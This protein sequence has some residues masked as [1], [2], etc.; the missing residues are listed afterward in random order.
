MAPLRLFAQQ[1]TLTLYRCPANAQ[2]PL[3]WKLPKFSN[4]WWNEQLIRCI[5]K[6]LVIVPSYCWSDFRLENGQSQR[7]PCDK[8]SQL[9]PWQRPSF[10]LDTATSAVVPA[11]GSSLIS[12]VRPRRNLFVV[13]PLPRN[14]LRCH[15]WQQHSQMASISLPNGAQ[16]SVDYLNIKEVRVQTNIRLTG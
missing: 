8:N 3:V 12:G 9:C 10:T 6:N 7:S 4:Y 14:K 13:K 11:N 15:H 16:N 5:F 2:R 1:N